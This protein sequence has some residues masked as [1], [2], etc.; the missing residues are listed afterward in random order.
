M[1]ET[2]SGRGTLKI[3]YGFNDDSSYRCSGDACYSCYDGVSIWP[4]TP[5]GSMAAVLCPEV[6]TT[7]HSSGKLHLGLVMSLLVNKKLT[8][9]GFL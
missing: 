8:T 1:S 4:Q 3:C 5:A 6:D 2:V 7:K 9:H